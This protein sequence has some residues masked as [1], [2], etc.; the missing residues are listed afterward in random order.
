MNDEPIEE[1]CDYYLNHYPVKGDNFTTDKI[2]EDAKRLAVIVDRIPK[3]ADGLPIISS[4]HPTIW[5]RVPF[6][7]DWQK[8]RVTSID[9][10]KVYGTVQDIPHSCIF[11]GCYFHKEN[12]PCSA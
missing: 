12:I 6:T 2:A 5:V 11:D 8:L 4:E 1:V 9:E 10:G 7:G 3:S